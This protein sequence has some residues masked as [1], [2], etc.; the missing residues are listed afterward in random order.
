MGTTEKTYKKKPLAVVHVKPVTGALG[1]TIQPGDEV[2]V[3]RSGY[4]NHVSC[5]KGTYIGYI[6]SEPTGQYRARVQMQKT[7]NEWFNKDGSQ[8]NW[9]DYDYRT[10]ED[11][12]KTLTIREIQYEVIT[13][14]WLNRIATLK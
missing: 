2:M 7:R 8:F 5:D 6:V 9:K 4:S 12:K 3:V 1:T 10:W 11:V 13:T 14:L